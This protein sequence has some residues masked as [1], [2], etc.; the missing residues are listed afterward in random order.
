MNP[1]CSIC[2]NI[3]LKLRNAS[4]VSDFKQFIK[5]I[6]DSSFILTYEIH[7]ILMD[8]KTGLQGF[9]VIDIQYAPK[10]WKSF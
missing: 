4:Q 9:V 6:F 7:S 8:S 3:L 1:Q 10:V 5:S 2:V